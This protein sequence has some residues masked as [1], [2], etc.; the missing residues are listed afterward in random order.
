VTLLY[1]GLNVVFIY[2]APLE[3]MKGVVAV[4]SL[5]ARNLFG[6]EIAGV[7]SALMAVSLM[8]TVNAMVTIGPRV[9]YAM[10]KN[11][12]FFPVAAQVSRRW[13]TPVIAIVTQGCCAMLM[14]MTP[15]AGLLMYIGFTLTLFAAMAVASLFLFR[16]RAGWQKLRVVSFAWPLMPLIFLAVA[17]WTFAMGIRLDPKTS[18]AA[19]LTIGTGAAIYHFVVRPKPRA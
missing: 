5:A 19:F 13:H 6:P 11:G 9:Y 12:A 10:A 17:G 1:V 2:G 7:F 14:T 15:F 4:G 3:S 18:L 8:S 16:R